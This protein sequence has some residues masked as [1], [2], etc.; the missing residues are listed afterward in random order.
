MG[1]HRVCQFCQHP[2]KTGH[3]LNGCL[4]ADCKCKRPNIPNITHI[5]N[6]PIDHY[7]AKYWM[8]GMLD[9]IGWITQVEKVFTTEHKGN[10]ISFPVDVHA[11]D[12]YGRELAIQLD[13]EI[14]SKSK[15]Q[16]GKTKN[17]D[18]TL[19]EYCKENNIE[20]HVIPKE[21]FKTRF[22]FMELR[23]SQ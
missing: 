21:N 14:H 20:Y 13:G 18:M 2:T 7:V 8:K 4:E 19:S 23:Q 16:I 17:R 1:N 9:E 10:L 12:K 5:R 6:E 15:I 11:I 3:S 22:A